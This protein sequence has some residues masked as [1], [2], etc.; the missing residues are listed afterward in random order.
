MINYKNL[1]EYLKET[2]DGEYLIRSLNDAY[3]LRNHLINLKEFIGYDFN[4]LFR[5]EQFYGWNIDSG[6]FRNTKAK[7]PSEGIELEKLAIEEFER[8]VRKEFGDKALRNIFNHK[9]FGREWDLLFQAQHAGV[10]TTLTDWT[11]VIEHALYFATEES[12]DIKIENSD[13]QLWCLMVSNDIVL[14]LGHDFPKKS[15]YKNDPFNLNQVY[16]IN[17]AIYIDNIK[18]RIFESRLY[19]QQG[20]FITLPKTNCNIPVNEIP[21]FKGLMSRIRISQKSKEKIR[22][23]LNEI[24]IN[25]EFLYVEENPDHNKLIEEIN[26]KIYSNK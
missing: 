19:K 20:K 16:L 15:I 24:G 9:E 3:E 5:G 1:E 18:D 22:N 2:L 12:K 10:K 13:A 4:P 7:S 11:M 21:E 8:V 14:N 17:S 26:K 25:R 6:V 23:E